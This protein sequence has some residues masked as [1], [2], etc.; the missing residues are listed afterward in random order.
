MKI[1]GN[2]FL[3]TL[4]P[5]EKSGEVVTKS[6]IILTSNPEH[7]KKGRLTK[8]KVI[9][10]SESYRHHKSGAS[11][12]PEV[13]VGDEILVYNPALAPIKLE[14]QDYYLVRLEDVEAVI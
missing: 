14:G 9:Q 6:G 5:S 8:A 12:D 13:Q 10:L 4:D 2:K 7:N 1:L 11:I 3:V